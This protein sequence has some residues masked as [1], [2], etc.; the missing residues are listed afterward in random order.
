MILNAKLCTAQDAEYIV[1]PVS[2][3]SAEIIIW[4]WMDGEDRHYI[5]SVSRICIMFL[6][7]KGYT[8]QI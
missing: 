2:L 6:I 3:C 7:L 4:D 5:A 8:C 1:P